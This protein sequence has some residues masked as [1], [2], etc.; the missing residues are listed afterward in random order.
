MLNGF[1]ARVGAV[2]NGLEYVMLCTAEAASST[3]SGGCEAWGGERGCLA[4]S[5]DGGDCVCMRQGRRAV[6][7]HVSRVALW[8]T[9][10][11]VDRG[12][13]AAF[14]GA[15]VDSSRQGWSR[16]GSEA[17]V[18]SQT[19]LARLVPLLAC[20]LHWGGMGGFGCSTLMTLP[21]LQWC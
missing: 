8:R 20:C 12:T 4:V 9:L 5:W 3:A 15:L 14:L 13:G 2:A 7:G 18:I 21:S 1:N 17:W 16:G 10:G 19:R 11:M 6:C